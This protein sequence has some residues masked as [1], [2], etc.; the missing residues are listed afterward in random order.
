VPFLPLLRQ[1]TLIM[2]GDDDPIIPLVNARLMHRLI[3]HSQLHV[4]HGGHLGLVTE[5]PQLAPVVDQFL[6]GPD[7]GAGNTRG[8]LDDNGSGR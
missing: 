6:A 5:A 8:G 2:S 1:P 7:P 3:P 4:F